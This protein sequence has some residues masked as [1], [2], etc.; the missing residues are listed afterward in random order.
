MKKIHLLFLAL[1]LFTYCHA[2]IPVPPADKAVIYFARPSGMGTLIN[3]TYFD[4]VTLVGKFNGGKYIRYECAPGHHIFWA[5]SENR[6]FI[7]A[8]VDA[9]KIYFI[10]AI[11]R[12]GALKAG[13]TLEAVN[14]RNPDSKKQLDHIL[15]L[16]SKRP[17]ES[18]TPEE[19]AAD[20]NHAAEIIVKGMTKYK[21]ELAKGNIQRLVPEM[22]YV[23]ATGTGQ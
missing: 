4:S 9:G 18:F 15:K 14:P 2:Q 16:I 12:M 7:D 11:P 19:L 3:F 22:N 1:I 6:D 13:V 21:E 20:T 23:P 8:N 10:E 17:S 5:R